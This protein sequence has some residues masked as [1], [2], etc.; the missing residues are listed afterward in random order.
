MTIHFKKAKTFHEIISNPIEKIC[1]K[2]V[3]IKLKY[4]QSKLNETNKIT[5]IQ[6]NK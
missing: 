2:S 5:N 4:V 1:K 6:Q 3:L